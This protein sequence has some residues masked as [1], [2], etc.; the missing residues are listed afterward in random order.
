MV[1]GQP[2]HND[3]DWDEVVDGM[4]SRGGVSALVLQVLNRVGVLGSLLDVLLQGA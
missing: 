3:R 2:E 4:G 1:G